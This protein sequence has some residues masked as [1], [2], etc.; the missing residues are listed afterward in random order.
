MVRNEKMTLAAQVREIIRRYEQ[1][2]RESIGGRAQLESALRDLDAAISE[3]KS[4]AEHLNIVLTQY[5]ELKKRGKGA[6]D[7]FLEK[8]RRKLDAKQHKRVPGG[9]PAGGAWAA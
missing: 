8:R 9:A 7:K 4:L 2:K 5:E 3:K 1:A 6:L